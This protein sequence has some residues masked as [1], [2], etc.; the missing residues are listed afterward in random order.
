MLAKQSQVSG[1]WHPG[2]FLEFLVPALF[3]AA[4]HFSITPAREF[5][6]QFFFRHD[7]HCRH[8]DE[9]IC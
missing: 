6:T 5:N 8:H 9:R 3:P 7:A 4:P 2:F 1:S